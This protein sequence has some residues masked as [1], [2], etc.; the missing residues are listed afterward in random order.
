MLTKFAPDIFMIN[1][2]I[3]IPKKADDM[4]MLQNGKVLEYSFLSFFQFLRFL[5]FLIVLYFDNFDRYIL[6]F[7]SS[8]KDMAITSF[9]EFREVEM[10][11]VISAGVF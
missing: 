11:L 4:R 3:L 6:S 2:L 5:R 1:R 10:Y 7:V 8:L 9:T